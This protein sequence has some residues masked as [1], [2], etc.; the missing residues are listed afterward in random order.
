ML[1]EEIEEGEVMK[2]E[3]MEKIIEENKRLK[4]KLEEAATKEMLNQGLINALTSKIEMHEFQMKIWEKNIDQVINSSEFSRFFN[5]RL[6]QH[7]MNFWSEKDRLD[8]FGM[9]FIEYKIY[10]VKELMLKAKSLNLNEAN[11]IFC[12]SNSNSRTFF[13]YPS[14]IQRKSLLNFIYFVL[15]PDSS[16]L[17][18]NDRNQEDIPYFERNIRKENHRDERYHEERVQQEEERRREAR[19]REER[20]R[21]ERQREERHRED[22]RLEERR[23]E[24]RRLEERRREARRREERLREKEERCRE[25]RDREERRREKRRRDIEYRYREDL[26]RSTKFRKQNGVPPSNSGEDQLLELEPPPQPPLQ[27]P[28]Q[29]PPQP[30]LEPLSFLDFIQI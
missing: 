5:G 17:F 13:I 8:K 23:R 24:D 25:E 7:V 14:N 18:M 29:P 28:L 27:P 30:P 16:M 12:F 10:N 21:E 11:K 19:R 15:N 3:E 1:I 9:M 22:R 4:E 2:R 26:L 20:Q 6:K